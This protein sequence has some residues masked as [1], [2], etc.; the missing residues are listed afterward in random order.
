MYLSFLTDFCSSWILWWILPFILGLLAGLLLWRHYKQK[1]Q[2]IEN[3]FKSQKAEIE[4]YKY[5]LRKT[6]TDLESTG[7][8]AERLTE[9]NNALQL[10]LSKSRRSLQMMQSQITEDPKIK[11]EDLKIKKEEPKVAKNLETNP[12]DK[13]HYEKSLE[14]DKA[15][16]S[17]V[18]AEITNPY[19]KLESTN[20]QI[21]EGIGPRLESILKE[22]G[23]NEWKDISSKS[24]GELRSVLDKYGGRY[25]IIDPSGWP[26]QAKLAKK[27]KWDELIALQSEDGSDSKL[28]KLLIKLGYKFD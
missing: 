21:I 11:K 15:S 9:K 8:Q 22:N 27:G 18:K 26:K 12:K 13:V 28:R 24:K 25:S 17:E 5:K 2:E 7:Y 19:P 23:L 4:N 10:E 14:K 6:E 20:L 1:Y 3:Q 16:K